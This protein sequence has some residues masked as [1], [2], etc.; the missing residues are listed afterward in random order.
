M[1]LNVKD[2]AQDGRFS[3]KIQE[4]EIE[5]RSSILP[6]AYSE[7]IVMRL[8]NPDQ[9]A[10]DLRELGIEP[11][12][13][14][15]FNTQLSKPDGLILNTGPTGSGKTTTLYAF[16]KQTLTP[17]IKIITI[18]DPIEYHLH[19]IVQTQVEH[20]KGYDFANG[21]RS[22]LRQD[23]DIIMVGEIRDIETAETAIH[24]S[25]TGHLVFSTLHTN[26]AAGAFTRLIDLGVNPKV[27]TSAI[28]LAIA[29]RLVRKLCPDCKKPA[30]LDSKKLELAQAIY[31]GIDKPKV[32]WNPNA[33]FQPG[34]GCST[35][36][37]LKY[38]GRV[39]LFEAVMSDKAIEDVLQMNPSER[40]IKEAARTQGIL[41]MSQD[42]IV[43]ALKGITD[44]G[45]LER[46]INLEAQTPKATLP[47]KE[48][49]FKELTNQD[50][51]A[52]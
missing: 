47:D 51:L 30:Q 34:E 5:I 22:A 27:L 44:I 33:F 21:L 52:Q 48:N 13:Q 49:G 40:E 31:N 6:G 37:G 41:D 15:L 24:A 20:E 46:V 36:N 43:K 12:L 45:E 10:V 42:G 38:K 2:Q 28:R 14:E 16:L 1:K 17:G 50:L 23:P 9:I 3:I 25:L 29:Q 18:E 11:E 4:T 8:L 39:A 35:C 32:E 26:T 7:S 19:G